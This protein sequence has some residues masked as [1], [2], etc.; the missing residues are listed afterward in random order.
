[1]G[2]GLAQVGNP[3]FRNK[4]AGYPR[5]GGSTGSKIWGDLSRYAIMRL[6]DST[7]IDDD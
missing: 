4:L 3:A 1:M 7:T 2:G 6:A 5:P